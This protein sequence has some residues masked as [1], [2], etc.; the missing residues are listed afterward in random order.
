MLKD[1]LTKKWVKNT[2]FCF[3]ALLAGAINGFIGTGGGILLVFALSGLQE[4]EKKDAFATSLCIT[5]PISAI[6][7]FNYYKAESANLSLLKDMW[8]PVL[9]GGMVGAL[10]VDKL[11]A[12]WLSCI[13]GGLV[14]YAGA[15]LIFK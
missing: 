4:I 11:R 10:L 1:F 14:I 8:L 5:V 12:S 13:F 9:L 6:A 7:F 2:L 3:I 15:C